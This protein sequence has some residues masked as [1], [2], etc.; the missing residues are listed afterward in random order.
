MFPMY[1]WSSVNFGSSNACEA[2]LD[3]D[4][5]LRPFPKYVTI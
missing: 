5:H 1:L 4:A 2:F 3:I